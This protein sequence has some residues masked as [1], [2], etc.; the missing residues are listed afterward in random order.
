MWIVKKRHTRQYH[1][2]DLLSAINARKKLITAGTAGVLV[3]LLVIH[4]L[5]PAVNASTWTQ[6]SDTDFNAGTL[7]ST[8]VSGSGS[9]AGIT[10]LNSGTFT[11]KR[12]V[13]IDNG[14]NG[15]STAYTRIAYWGSNG[16]GNG[17]FDGGSG[18]ATDSSGNVYVA[19]G[20]NNRI[21]KF[22]SSGNYLTQWPTQGPLGVASDS[23]DNIYVAEY[24]TDLV[25]K[26]SSSGTLLLTWGSTGNGDGQFN[27]PSGIAVDTSGNVYVTDIWNY[28]VQKFN[29][30]GGYVTKWGSYGSSTSQF[31][32]PMGIAVDT[33]GNVFVSEQDNARIQ[34][35]DSS[36]T[37]LSQFALGTTSYLIAIDTLGNIYAMLSTWKVAKYTNSGSF[38]TQWNSADTGV[39][40]DNQGNVYVT[41]MFSVSDP[42]KVQ[43]YSNATGYTNNRVTISLTS[44][45]FNFSNAQS[46]GRDIRFFNSDDTTSLS[47]YLAS[48]NAGAQ[49]G[50]VLVQIPTISVSSTPT[51]YM[52]YGDA[53]ASSTSDASVSSA[54]DS[55]LSVTVGSESSVSRTVYPTSGTLTSSAFNTG[56]LS[57]FSTLTWTATTPTNT[58]VKFQLRSASTENGLSS[59]T[60]YGPTGTGDFYTSS[61]TSINS[62]HNG[63]TW[64]QYIATLTTT[65]TSTSPT[66][67]D[68]SVGYALAS[69][70]YTSPTTIGTIT[71]NNLTI[72]G[73]TVTVTGGST[74][75]VQGT[76]TIINGG[77]LLLQSTNTT[78][79]SGGVGVT[80][81]AGDVSIDTTSSISA[82]GQGYT[83]VTQGA[84]HGP[85]GGGAG[86]GGGGGGYG[87]AGGNGVGA[88]GGVS[89]GSATAPT[90]LGSAGGA[91]DCCGRIGSAGGGAI[92]LVVTGTLTLNGTV[93]SNG[94]N[95]AGDYPYAGAGS[96][97]SIYVTTG[98]LTGSG[99]FTA[100]GGSLNNT[101][102]G[103]GGGAGGRI[104]VYYTTNT[105]L[106]TLT[107]NGG[108][109]TQSGGTGTST[110]DIYVSSIPTGNVAIMNLSDTIS[111]SRINVSADHNIQFTASSTFSSAQTITV[112]F[113]SGFSIPGSFSYTDVDL[114]I[115]GS[116]VTLGASASGATWGVSINTGSRI[117]TITSGTG[118]ISNGTAVQ[119]LLG[120]NASSGGTGVYQITNPSSAGSYRINIVSGY[121]SGETMVAIT[122]GVTMSGS[123]SSTLQ[124][125]ISGVNSGIVL[126]GSITT[127]VV[128]TG[129]AIPWGVLTSSTALVAAQHL[130][131]QTNAN[132]GFIVKVR[133]TQNFQ[134][135][136]Y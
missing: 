129:T 69:K 40:V 94:A 96:G 103:G 97:G 110:L 14:P 121:D 101:G 127:D 75:T 99:T 20:G 58:V 131:V 53:N 36:G 54:T 28:R 105:F 120:T 3:S 134:S 5:T 16:S 113:A 64:V 59:A 47:Y 51:I 18:I 15:N 77:K 114:L 25:K 8:T 79:N 34:K 35:F 104:A 7:S 44:S 6:T 30:S 98:T 60:A 132:N 125:V 63:D 80:V 108:I 57:D 92:R 62:V 70:T 95:V 46:D 1:F 100:N 61:G 4:L 82:D 122:N 83:A 38:I 111:D 93:T 73:T 126:D 107:V 85:G 48:W 130:A 89:Y 41:D 37:Y 32:R 71:V 102:G 55:G 9:G 29:S 65:D 72:N 128:T 22:D 66:L 87:A 115:G 67:S 21:Q 2:K 76:L 124:L 49:T 109:G 24:G 86:S 91:G 119:I 118:T 135:A 45:N 23:S 68:T 12:G 56:Q 52:Y 50:S 117:I 106:G 136:A 13:V 42:T 116:N 26:F 90:D 43:K 33:S 84:G 81:N 17:Q 11:K 88:T 39:A 31:A 74:L 19:D 78:Q 133:Q 112:T 123:V 27:G 10:L